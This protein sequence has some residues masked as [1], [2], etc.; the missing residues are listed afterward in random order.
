LC[1]LRRCAPS[2]GAEGAKDSLESSSA[3]LSLASTSAND[4]P[5]IG[6][7]QEDKQPDKDHED[8]D[9]DQGEHQRAKKGTFKGARRRRLQA[10]TPRA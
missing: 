9:A 8:L 6:D 1:E 4:L 5:V 7:T 10:G 3:R 2:L